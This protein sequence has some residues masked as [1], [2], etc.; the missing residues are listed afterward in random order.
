MLK[1]PGKSGSGSIRRWVKML[2]I[3]QEMGS[4]QEDYGI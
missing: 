2:G 3:K 1:P 4:P